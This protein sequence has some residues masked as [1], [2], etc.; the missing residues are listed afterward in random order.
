MWSPVLSS[1]GRPVLRKCR[2]VGEVVHRRVA[3]E[4]SSVQERP[5]NLRN[6]CCVDGLGKHPAKRETSTDG[7]RRGDQTLLPSS[8]FVNLRYRRLSYSESSLNGVLSS[9]FQARLLSY[10]V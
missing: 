4:V 5:C 1:L 2:E 9:L 7:L 8:P 10:F 3:C 6:S